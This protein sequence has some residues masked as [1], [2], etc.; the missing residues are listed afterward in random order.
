ML[1]HP[2][3]GRRGWFNQVAFL[4]EWTLD[5]V[6]REYLKFEFGEDGLPF[7][8][9]YGSGAAIDEATVRTVN[10]VYEKHTLRE[11]WRA[12]DLMI[13]DNLRMAHSREEYTGTREIA[14]VLG[15][16]VPIPAVKVTEGP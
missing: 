16:P 13:V 1:R 6:V 7:N 3:S 11:S 14:V 5:P 8:T 4:S 10:E 12:G 9:A 2:V 15:A